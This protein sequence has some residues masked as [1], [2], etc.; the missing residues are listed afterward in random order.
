[1]KQT[2]H[3]TEPNP[4]PNFKNLLESKMEYANHDELQNKLIYLAINGI[5]K[6]ISRIEPLA[7]HLG[8]N[9]SFLCLYFNQY[10]LRASTFQ[11]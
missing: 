6:Q 8:K 1:M 11:N 10:W 4:R 5:R 3:I 9:L 2:Q 7:P